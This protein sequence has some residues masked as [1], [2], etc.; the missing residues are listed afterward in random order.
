MFFLNEFLKLFKLFIC[1]K[2][3]GILPKSCMLLKH[4]W[5]SKWDFLALNGILSTPTILENGT[6]HS[7]HHCWVKY[8]SY[9]ASNSPEWKDRSSSGCWRISNPSSHHHHQLFFQKRLVK[10][11]VNA[12]KG[13][14]STDNTWWHDGIQKVL[15][16]GK[17][18]DL[19]GNFSWGEILEACGKI[20]W[21][22]P[23]KRLKCSISPWQGEMSCQKPREGKKCSLW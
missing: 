8:F 4:L 7:F 3:S 13:A 15:G 12:S 16:R 17:T 22:E 1:K 5:S 11:S 14:K 18:P 19:K 10:A 20:V 9:N 2:N 23:F 21:R 6:F